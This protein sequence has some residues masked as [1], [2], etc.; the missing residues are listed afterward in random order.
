V[1]HI[2]CATMICVVFRDSPQSRAWIAANVTSH[3]GSLKNMGLP[4][5]WMAYKC[6]EWEI[7]E[8]PAVLLHIEIHDLEI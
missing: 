3:K 4:Q 8:H 6:L 7:M 1:F 2:T 5:K